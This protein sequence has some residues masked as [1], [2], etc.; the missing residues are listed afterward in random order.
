MRRGR[1]SH[2]I[3]VKT[4]KETKETPYYHSLKLKRP[5]L[6]LLTTQK[7]D[8]NHFICIKKYVK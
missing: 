8:K 2:V 7:A 4:S 3:C 6:F 1:G 5:T